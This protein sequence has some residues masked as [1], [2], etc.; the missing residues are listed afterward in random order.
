V[1]VVD[2]GLAAINHGES[3]LTRTGVLLGTPTYMAPEQVRSRTIDARTDI[4]SLGVI[5]YEIFT[6]RPPYAGDDPMAILFQHVEGKPRPPRQVQA[7]ITP[8]LE[9]VILKAMAPD[10]EKR[11]QSMDALRRGIAELT[12]PVSR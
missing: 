3:R 8:G 9:A 2:F 10:P 12:K 11:Y 7:D 1:K 4:Y 6:G 5:M